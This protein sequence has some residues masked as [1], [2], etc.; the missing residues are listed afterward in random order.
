MSFF[1]HP[2]GRYG[3]RGSIFLFTVAAFLVGAGTARTQE[4]AEVLSLDA[5]G[6]VSV[7]ATRLTSEFDLDGRLDESIYQQ[8][9]PL[10]D[11]TQQIPEEGE[12]GSERT[13]AWVFFD[14]DNI[15][16]GARNHESVPPSEW[17][18]NEM[19]RD[20]IQLRQN[21]SF[22]VMLDTFFDRRNGAAFLVTPIGGF[23]D[24]AISNEGQR[25]NSDWNVVWDSRTARYDGGWTVEM[26]IPF[27]SL[28]FRPGRD[29]TWGIQLR[30]IIRRRNEA[31]YLT[32]LPISAARGNSVIAGLWRI[33]E[34]A[35]LT[36][37]Q[38][39][40]QSLNA[41]VKPYGIGRMTTD[42][43]VTPEV[44]KDFN[45]D[46]GFDVKYG[47]TSNLTAD[48]TYNTDFAQVEVDEQQV[49][50]TRFS[51]FFPEKREFFLEGRGNFDFA[52]GAR[53]SAGDGT[54]SAPTMFFS[55]R[56]GL[57]QGKVVPILAGS[58]ITG[59]VGAFDVGA[60]NI[61]TDA[62]DLSG[63]ESTN[64]TVLRLKRDVLR[65]STVGAIFTNRSVSLTGSGT[66][67]LY[68]ADA[69]L[70]F[71][72]DVNLL[73]YLAKS[74][75]TG[76]NSH[77][78][79]YMGRFGY[80]GDR[81]GLQA[82]YLVVEDNFNPEVGF[83]RR[84]DFDQATGSAR[85]SP[86]PQSIS[87]IRRFNL[88]AST[89]W[90]WSKRGGELETRQHRAQFATE[91]ENSDQISFSVSNEFEQLYYTFPISQDVDLRAGNY[92]FT[93]F[94]TSYS[95]GQQRPVSGTLSLR[96]GEFW[97]G[98]NTSLGFNRGRIEMTPQLSFEPS[99]SVN[100]VTM[101]EG[102]FTTHLGRVRFT[103][104][105]TPRMYLSGLGQY[106]SSL[107]TFSTNLRFRWEWSPGSEVFLVYTEDLSTDP[108]VP[109]R[110]TEL[111]NR[112]L[113][114]KINRLLQF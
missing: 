75:T 111:R 7:R 87:W 57:Q 21:D 13:E 19:R 29:Q 72:D 97:S 110:M 31:S 40:G 109:N 93:S 60:L 3:T 22:S 90:L 5:D 91:L 52:L 84:D 28:R 63:V 34:A 108:F 99:Y 35:T 53:G 103:Y 96:T 64:F 30:R 106:N 61:Q 65:R 82:G 102:D 100:W 1:D 74:Q 113:V 8:L 51:L 36:D 26:R 12:L 73:G 25:V 114:I 56:I 89:D 66:N 105:F 9:K 98:N 81:Y 33:S 24:F 50:L 78:L 54:V 32:P 38:V 71:G 20:V 101:P 62:G 41:E 83:L 94:R 86:R 14:D 17:V 107:N 68:G 48:F 16:I 104:T 37:L 2:W 4:P 112:G 42:R 58:R 10:T 44:G 49:N 23:S 27:K 88:N 6:R 43:T 69:A 70:A 77:D 92:D 67:Q 76:L 59:K 45:Q 46:L 80:T 55:R 11:F 39:P 47:I 18:A 79:S 85:F 15:Y 95:F